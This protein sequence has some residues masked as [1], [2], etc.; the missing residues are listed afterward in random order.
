M[1]TTL[2]CLCAV[3]ACALVT[4]DAWSQGADDRRR[5]AAPAAAETANASPIFGV[6]VPEG[7]RRWTLIAPSHVP[8]FDELRSILGNAL[9][10]KA[11][12]DETLPFP[13]GTVL[14]KLPGSMLPRR[15][16]TALL[17]PARRRMFRSW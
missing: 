11:Y 17:L 14:V 10:V 2:K 15:S 16:S 8:S 12:G 9:A 6:T 7:Y 1:P 5:P 4:T 13:D 3:L